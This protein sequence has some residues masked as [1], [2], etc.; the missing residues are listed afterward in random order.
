MTIFL[1]DGSLF[2]FDLRQRFYFAHSPVR[3]EIVQLTQTLTIFLSRHD[4]PLVPLKSFL[5]NY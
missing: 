5:A 1:V 3:G 2:M 4:Y